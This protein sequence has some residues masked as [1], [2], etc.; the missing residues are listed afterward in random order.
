MQHQLAQRAHHEEGE[1]T[2]DRVGHRQRR[3]GAG[4][5]AARA[6][7]QPGADGPADRDHVDVPG[8]EGLLVPGVTG[9]HMPARRPL[10]GL[11]SCSLLLLPFRLPEGLLAHA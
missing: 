5:P 11:L 3:P 8:L 2:A 4:E 9:V 1:Q 10:R 7:E 6:E